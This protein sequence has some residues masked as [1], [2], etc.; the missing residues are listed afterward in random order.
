DSSARVAVAA[1]V[2]EECGRDLSAE[3]RARESER[4]HLAESGAGT[5]GLRADEQAAAA[6]LHAGGEAHRAREGRW[7]DQPRERPAVAQRLLAR[8]RALFLEDR[9]L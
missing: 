8:S 9:E 1:C 3:L 6:I 5:A 4:E 7:T 2:H